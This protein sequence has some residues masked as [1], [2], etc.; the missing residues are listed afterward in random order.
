MYYDLLV[1]PSK[2]SLRGYFNWEG[3]DLNG[4][5]SKMSRVGGYLVWVAKTLTVRQ[6]AGHAGVGGGALVNIAFV[7]LLLVK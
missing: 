6:P 4:A 5:I 7:W 2:C 1:A 3:G